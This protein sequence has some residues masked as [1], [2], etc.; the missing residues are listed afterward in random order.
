MLNAIRNNYLF[1][2]GHTLASFLQ[3]FLTDRCNITFQKDLSQDNKIRS[4]IQTMDVDGLKLVFG[5]GTPFTDTAENNEAP[6]DITE[7]RVTK[8]Y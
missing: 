4:F 7:I 1:I 5:N 2:R 3:A 6:R 8:E